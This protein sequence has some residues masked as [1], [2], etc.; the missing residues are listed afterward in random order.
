MLVDIFLVAMVEQTM[1]FCILW[2]LLVVFREYADNLF[3][4]QHYALRAVM[5]WVSAAAKL[6]KM[7][8]RKLTMEEKK[9]RRRA[10]KDRDLPSFQQH[11]QEQ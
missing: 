6:K 1:R 10:L 8:Q 11:I 7:G 2:F 5:F 3:G 4:A 9:I